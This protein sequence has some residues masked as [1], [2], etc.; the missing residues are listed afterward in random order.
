MR[1]SYL[2]LEVKLV[3]GRGYDTHKLKEAMKEQKNEEQPTDAEGSDE[4]D[5]TNSVPLLSYVNNSMHSIFS[6]VQM[7]SM[8]TSRIF[9]TNLRKRFLNNKVFCIVKDMT[10]TR[11][12]MTFKTHYCLIPS[13]QEYRKCQ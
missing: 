1:Q 6:N 12:L 11:I 10:W 4:E 7:D 13:F 9:P 3:K 5:Y 2:A 8:L